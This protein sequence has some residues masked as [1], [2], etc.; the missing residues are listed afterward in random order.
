MS[1]TCNQ[2]GN[3]YQRIGS[4]W[5]QNSSCS[6][7]EFTDHQYEI[8]T[9]ILM[10]DGYVTKGSGNRKPILQVEM[11]SKN[12]LNY[13]ANEFGVLGGKV[14]MKQTSAEKAKENRESGFSPN[15]KKENYSDV[16]RWSS[17]RHPELYEF[18][19]WYFSGKKV[20]PKN[21][22]LT[23]TT[24]KHWYCGDGHFHNSG[25][26]DHI[27]IAMSNE[28]EETKKVSKMF[29]T[30]GLP[31]PSNY[32]TSELKNGSEAC[33]A[34]F[35]VSQS[36]ELWEYMGEPLPDFEYKWPKEYSNS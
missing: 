31:S 22:E 17:I 35:T 29:E 12:Y 27:R 19:D 16:Y 6:Y 14:K 32:A 11:I 36:E 28:A 24:L 1:K 18:Y 26:T 8:I 34:E 33:T 5:V 15:A 10:G 9:G 2:C 13:I 25:T 21:I 30:A 20:W 4:H 3:E 7:K 23:S